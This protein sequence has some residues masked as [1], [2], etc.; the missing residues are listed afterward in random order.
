MATAK[1]HA[2]AAQR[3]PRR[4][5]AT[6]LAL[7]GLALLLLALAMG[8]NQLSLRATGAAAYAARV[9]C[10]CRYVAGRALSDCR[11]DL[12]EGMGP[13]QLGEDAAGRAVTARYLLFPTQTAR[14]YEGAGCVL[15]P[16]R[17]P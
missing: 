2:Q 16:W 7:A 15:G 3:Q 10:S 4:R 13:V 5:W 6:K 1:P 17:R 12:I 8:W 9:G 14:L 11:K